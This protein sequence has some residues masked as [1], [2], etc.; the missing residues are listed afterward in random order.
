MNNFSSS[1][2]LELITTVVFASALLSHHLSFSF[3]NLTLVSRFRLISLLISLFIYLSCLI[4]RSYLSPP[5]SSHPLFTPPSLPQLSAFSFSSVCFDCL[6]LN[7]GEP[8]SPQT[9]CSPCPPPFF[10][11]PCQPFHLLCSAVDFFFSPSLS[12]AHP[13]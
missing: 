9:H 2:T 11:F 4:S 10:L 3:N 6:F 5:I 12:T 1:G 7:L 8:K 13:S